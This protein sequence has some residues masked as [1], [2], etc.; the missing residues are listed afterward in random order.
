MLLELEHSF[1]QRKSTA[2]VIQ[3]ELGVNPEEFD[4]QLR[5]WLDKDVGK[6]VASFD[7][8]RKR[9]KSLAEMA[10]SRKYEDVIREGKDVVEMYPDYVYD[11]NAYEFV[12]EADLAMSDDRSAAAVL[13]DYEKIGGR[14]PEALKK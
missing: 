6:T 10:E 9:L 1:A 5:V 3:Q 13:T 2:E 14:S 8:W 12:A 7:E 11:A 4:K